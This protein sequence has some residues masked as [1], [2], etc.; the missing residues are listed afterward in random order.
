[1]TKEEK[2]LDKIEAKKKKD[3]LYRECITNGLCPECGEGIMEERRGVVSFFGLGCIGAQY[4]YKC[5]N[6][7][8]SW[9]KFKY[10]TYN[11]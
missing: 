5:S 6:G 10:D 11:R 3:Y 8:C 4:W 1:M 2:L 9:E 7:K